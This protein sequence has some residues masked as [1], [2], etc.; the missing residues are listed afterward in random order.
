MPT[1]TRMKE[2]VS[3][4]NDACQSYYS[5]KEESPM[6]DAQYD[7]Y[8]T[9]LQELEASAGY[10]LSE[11]PTIK[12]GWTEVEDKIKHY[13][14]I[15]SLKDTKDIDDLMH[16]LGEREGV[17]SWK[18]DGVS[19]VLYYQNGS[20][21]RAVSRGDG[22]I[23]KDI[24]RNVS[25]IQDV[26]KKIE[27]KDLIIIRGE[28][29]ITLSDFEELKQSPEGE[30]YRNPRN[31]ASG[32]INSTLGTRDHLLSKLTFITHSIIFMEDLEARLQTRSKMFHYMKTLGF[33]V[34][35]HVKV[36][37]YTLKPEIK[38]FTNNV[39]NFDFPVDGLVLVLND[40]VYGASLGQ[41][42]RFPRDSMAFKW[43]DT[44]KLTQV[45][46]MKWSVSQTGL[47]TPVLLVKPVELE[48]TTVKQAN[49]HSLKIFEDLGIG[50][51]DTVEIFKANKIIPEVKEN[52]TRSGTE[53]YP[54]K[55]PVCGGPTVVMSGVKT[56]KLYCIQCAGDQ[57]PEDVKEAY[58]SKI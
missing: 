3:L 12:V 40:L 28:G 18:L 7:Q 25:L 46:G 56:R 14:P 21:D 47:I 38:A 8:L 41:T 20:L 26:P 9:E 43:P 52:L 24:T 37:N 50:V 35:P 2:L 31:L 13:L 54:R 17:L 33:K 36:A 42:A 49:L 27:Y 22:E 55:C 39:E 44:S 34:V 29:C 15:L 30:K 32:L 23:G 48:G 1:E 6:T 51:G 5:G 53:T 16:F 57:L 19:I 4:L 11:S 45:Q 58:L 10:R